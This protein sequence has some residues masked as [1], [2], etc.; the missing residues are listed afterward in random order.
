MMP[1]PE[2]PTAAALARCELG[3][4]PT[5]RMPQLHFPDAACA[6][7]VPDVPPPSGPCWRRALDDGHGSSQVIG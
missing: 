7:R 5:C 1:L 3:A 6:H 2:L 4:G